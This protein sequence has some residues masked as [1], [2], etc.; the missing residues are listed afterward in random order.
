[1]AILTVTDNSA[2]APASSDLHFVDAWDGQWRIVRCH[3]KH[4]LSAAQFLEE[5]AGIS[6][7]CPTRR[8][9]TFYGKYQRKLERIVPI[10][11][12]YVFACAVNLDDLYRACDF[13]DARWINSIETVYRQRE[14]SAQL[15]AFQRI[16]ENEKNFAVVYD[17][18]RGQRVKVARGPLYGIE[19]FFYKFKD[20]P[21]LVAVI[22]QLGKGIEI[23]IDPSILEAA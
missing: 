17:F 4:T 8:R 6:C 3:A 11:P 15:G 23:E 2:A 1:M 7:F 9:V 5:G 14:F 19:G 16:C 22:D 12:S 21:K 18:S 13:H 20:G 10:L